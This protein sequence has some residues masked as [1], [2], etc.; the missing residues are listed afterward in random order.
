MNC[1]PEAFDRIAGLVRSPFRFSASGTIDTAEDRHAGAFF[2]PALSCPS[3]TAAQLQ[4]QTTENGLLSA[5]Q[6]TTAAELAAWGITAGSVDLCGPILRWALVHASAQEHFLDLRSHKLDP[7]TSVTH[8]AMTLTALLAAHVR[9]GTTLALPQADLDLQKDP[10]ASGGRWIDQL[11]DRA[12][13]ALRGSEQSHKRNLMHHMCSCTA[14]QS[15]FAR[16]SRCR[17]P[18][19]PNPLCPSLPHSVE[20]LE[21]LAF[22]L[23]YELEDDRRHL[24]GD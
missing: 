11:P 19:H 8:Q 21:Q 7:R 12:A 22:P 9:S 18:D 3:L 2:K 24:S 20:V 15:R 1:T 5:L 4:G 6:S 14:M 13:C 23:I 10:G 17:R 16:C